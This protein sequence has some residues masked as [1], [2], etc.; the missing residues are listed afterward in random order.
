MCAMIL[1]CLFLSLCAAV[2][3][4]K[5]DFAVNV[6]SDGTYSVV[7]QGDVWLKSAPTFF[8]ADGQVFSSADGSLKL[9]KN[10]Q[11]SGVDIIGQWEAN[12]FLY[13]AGSSQIEASFVQYTPDPSIFTYNN[14]ALP[15]MLFKQ[16]YINGANNTASKI[17]NFTISGFPGFLIQES[18]IPL[19]YLSYGG[20]QAGSIGL[21]VGQWGP[22]SFTINDGIEGGPLTIFDRVKTANTLIISPASRFMSS[23]IWRQNSSTGGDNVYWGTMGRVEDVPVGVETSFILFCGNQGINKASVSW[24]QILQRWHGRTDQYVKSDFTI[25]Y[26][27]FW[28]DNGAYYYY[29]TEKGKNHQDTM[30][31]IKSYM[32][33][34][35]VPVRYIQYDEWWY[36][37]DNGFVYLPGTFSIT[38]GG[39]TG[40]MVLFTY[41]VHSV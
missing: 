13:K 25:N 12:S 35:G 19:G 2:S 17:S 15:F 11:S 36:Y 30:L 1:L 22:S 21:I 16:R 7:V 38:N 32:V 37:W 28:T 5:Q 6:N 18:T 14:P 39:A 24:G 26:L 3:E 20:S 34:I 9:V 40:T 29:V 33:Q 27:G 41:Q 31:D 4:G 23:S 8:R 10:T